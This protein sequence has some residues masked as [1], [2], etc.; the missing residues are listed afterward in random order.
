M[1]MLEIPEACILAQ[2][3][4]ETVSGKRII[5][6]MANST[7]HKMAFYYEDPQAYPDLLSG[8]QIDKAVAYGG[9]VE[10]RAG[11]KIILMGD[12]VGLRYHEMGAQRPLK[13]QLLLEFNDGS[14]LSAKVQMYGGIWCFP[15]GKFDNFYY[16]VAREKPS[17]LTEEFD[18]DY[19]ERLIASPE[20]QKLSVKAFL[21]TE[22]RIPGLG[23]GVLQDIVWQVKIH[24]KRKVRTLTQIEKDNLFAAVK[25]TLQLMAE[26]GG[27][28][29]EKDLFGRSGSYKT[30]MSKNHAGEPCPVCGTKIVKQAYMGGSIY[31]CFGCQKV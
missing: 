22:Q 2:Q 1:F 29:T 15:E 5:K 25:K 8:E 19:F 17:P 23:N 14:A 3:L 6:V 9:L 20:A 27:R 10:I 21:A 13:H 16:K 28:D 30:V 24:P 7:P 26:K 31:F 18:R 11:K 4:N 12:G